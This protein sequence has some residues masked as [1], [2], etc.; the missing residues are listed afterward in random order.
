MSTVLVRIAVFV[1]AAAVLVLEIVAGR[2]L[3]PYV[4][5]SLQTFTGIIGTILAAI[6]LGAWIGGRAADRYDPDRLLG[7]VLIVGGVLAVVSPAVVYV[8]GPNATSEGP[9]TIIALAAIGFFLPAAVL[10]TVTPIAAKASLSSLESTGVVVGQLSALGTAGALFGTFV[11]G[12]VLIAS[13]PSQPITWFVGAVLV[14]LGSALSWSGMRTAV[15]VGVLA[16]SFA[17]VGASAIAAP[18]DHETAYSCAIITGPNDAPTVK[19]LILDTF[20]NSVVDTEDPAWLSSRY[21]RAMDAVVASRVDGSFNG[22]YVGGGG[23]AMPRYYEATRGS[24]A[25][26][27]EI[28]PALPPIAFD[29]L[30]LVD[31]PWLT[32]VTGDARVGLRSAA[33]PFEVIVGDAFSGRS[34][35]WHLTTKEFISQLD[36]VLTPDG[37]YA[38]NV[39][40]HPPNEFVRAELV[41]LASVFDHVVLVSPQRQLDGGR[42]GNYILAGSRTPFDGDR[43][44][45]LVTDGEVVLVDAEALDWARGGLVLIDE[46]APTDQL[47][48]RPQP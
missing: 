39:I 36:E 24:S 1:A 42:G 30:G 44:A 10:S 48:S 32:I 20:V 18:C 35:P 29:E 13:M 17:V 40:A 46:F 25:T 15:V 5:V 41:T 16:L 33:G 22:L 31:G 9:L 12:F 8:V 23:F 47:L 14:L 38:I 43:I 2:I 27:L 26:V 6:A 37:V 7:P 11:T 19:A 45:N 3:A 28:D 34:V 21:A 4:G